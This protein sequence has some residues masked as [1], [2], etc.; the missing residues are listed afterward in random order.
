MGMSIHVHRFGGRLDDS[1]PRVERAA[2]T[3]ADSGE[4]S[5]WVEGES[6]MQRRLD[7]IDSLFGAARRKGWEL[8][9]V[10]HLGRIV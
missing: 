7:L 6:V 4:A 5:F 3:H 1:T 10:Q 8:G 9:P 2:A